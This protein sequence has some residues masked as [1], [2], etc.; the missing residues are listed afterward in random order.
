MT[1]QETNRGAVAVTNSGAA[2][3]RLVLE[4]WGDETL[5][6]PATTVRISFEGPQGGLLEIA[7]KP[8]QITVFGWEG[9]VLGMDADELT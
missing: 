1:T 8:G 6:P 3:V 5:V 7:V 2:P 4:P 9:S